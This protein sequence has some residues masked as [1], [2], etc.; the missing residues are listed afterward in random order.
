MPRESAEL[1]KL[2]EPAVSA[3]GFELVGV[4]FV[5]GRR[6]LLRVY[7]DS[8]DGIS[9]DDCQA[10]S[11]QV[12]GLL[13]VED[14]IPGQYS[15]EVSS[16]GLDRPLFRAA[17]FERFAGH[18]VRLRLVAPVEGRRKFRGVLVGLRDGRVVVQVEEQEL[19]V[20]LEE[21]DEARLVPDYDSHRL[22]G[23]Q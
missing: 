19:V 5:S 23:A 17:D 21:I 12:S 2:L 7:I 6:G 4:E 11:H 9:I 10:V 3:L 15:L 22:E 18:E 20:A 1:R 8:E 16:P 14:P 13:D